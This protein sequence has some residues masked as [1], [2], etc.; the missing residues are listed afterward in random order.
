MFFD[1]R[2]PR[3]GDE[4]L[5]RLLEPL[6]EQAAKLAMTPD[7]GI[8]EYRGSKRVHTHSAAMCWSGCQRLGAIANNLGLADR[9]AYWST[10]A[11]KIGE[12]V[13]SRSWNPKRNAFSPPSTATISTPV[14]C[15]WR[16]S[17]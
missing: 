12:E 4:A 5:F 7:S 14:R 9:A 1:R 10:T 17:G 3:P 13:L 16:K 8:W 6:G 15:F 2:L 11:A